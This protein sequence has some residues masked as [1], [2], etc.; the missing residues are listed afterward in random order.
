[1]RT[2]SSATRKMLSVNAQKHNIVAREGRDSAIGASW[3]ESAVVEMLNGRGASR[4]CCTLVF[5]SWAADVVE[6]IENWAGLLELSGVLFVLD[7]FR[8]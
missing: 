5:T 6:K 1:M 8:E 2:V 3:V 4:S 7:E